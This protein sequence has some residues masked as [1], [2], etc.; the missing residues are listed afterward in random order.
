MHIKRFDR[1]YSRRHF[2]S[3]LAQGAAHRRAVATVADAGGQGSAEGVY[4]DELLSLTAYTQGAIQEGDTINA[5]NV[6][7]VRELLDPIQYLQVSEMGRELNVVAPTQDLYRLSPW[8]YIE[9]TLRHQGRARFADDGNVV[10]TEGKPWIG[11]NP[12]PDPR[13]ASEV[14]AGATLSWGRHD[15][16]FYAVK[17]YDL[18]PDGIVSYEY[19]S[20]W[21]E[22]NATGRIV[23]EPKPYMKGHED[24]LRFQSVFFDAE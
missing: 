3:E 6:E 9:A 7:S 16:S 4:P 8:E 15:V 2:L 13:S 20:C 1:A 12:F 22:M 10:T 23:I 17:E 14:F 24:T 5:D 18:D 21:V 19:Q 11:G